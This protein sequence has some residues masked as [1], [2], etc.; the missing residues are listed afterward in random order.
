V[1]TG[2]TGDKAELARPAASVHRAAEHRGKAS[3][4]TI[5]NPCLVLAAGTTGAT[6]GFPRRDARRIKLQMLKEKRPAFRTIEGWA[7]SILLE[8]GE[9]GAQLD[10]G[11][12]RSADL[13]RAIEPLAVSLEHA[14]A[15]G[16]GGECKRTR[17]ESSYAAGGAHDN[18]SNAD[19]RDVTSPDKLSPSI[20]RLILRST[21]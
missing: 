12:D 3:A 17:P 11:S 1:V 19:P 7:I 21:S 2:G 8:A 20:R 15:A 13:Q 10:E 16:T 9:R 6:Q 14:T 5:P 4:P 18:P